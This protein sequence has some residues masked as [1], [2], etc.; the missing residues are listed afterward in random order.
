MWV[1]ILM[2]GVT[3]IQAVFLLFIYHRVS[4]VGYAE[5]Q[6]DVQRI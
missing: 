2:L 1:S 5:Q 3:V 4:A 6:D